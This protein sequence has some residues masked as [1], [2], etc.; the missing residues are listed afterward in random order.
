[1]MRRPS[2]PCRDAEAARATEA[3]PIERHLARGVIAQRESRGRLGSWK[4]EGIEGLVEEA[5]AF[6]GNGGDTAE[7]PNV[8][9]QRVPAA[10]ATAPLRVAEAGRCHRR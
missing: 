5:A 10:R 7:Q 6:A 3:R 9:R 8:W 2:T 4:E 1:M